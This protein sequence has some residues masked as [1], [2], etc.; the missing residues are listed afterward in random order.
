LSDAY[1]AHRNEKKKDCPKA[2]LTEEEVMS[3]Q[4]T[5][6]APQAVTERYISNLLKGGINDAFEIRELISKDSVVDGVIVGCYYEV[7][8]G[9]INKPYVSAVGATPMQAVRRALEKHGVTFR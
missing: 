4:E 7:T 9:A 2:G 3:E 6:T 8:I 1:V 5:T